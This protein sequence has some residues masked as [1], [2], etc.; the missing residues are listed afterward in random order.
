MG[1]SVCSTSLAKEQMAPLRTAKQDMVATTAN[2]GMQLTANLATGNR[3]HKPLTLDTKTL[4]E[5]LRPVHMGSMITRNTGKQDTARL[6]QHRL[7][8]L[9]KAMIILPTSKQ[10]AIKDMLPLQLLEEA[11]NGRSTKCQMEH[12]TG[13][14]QQPEFRSGKSHPE[15][16]EKNDGNS[17]RL[18]LFSS[19]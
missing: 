13:I 14:I 4:M 2:R 15:C 5:Q 11:Q 6:V 7:L 10:E 19:A 16:R 8:L 9:D 12:R 3:E 1:L 18:R 17:L